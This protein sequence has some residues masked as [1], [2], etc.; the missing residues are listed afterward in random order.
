MMYT[1]EGGAIGGKVMANGG[2]SED[3]KLVFEKL[4]NL[5]DTS[6]KIWALYITWQNWFIGISAAA[7]GAFAVYFNQLNKV[8]GC[9][10]GVAICGAAVFGICAAR[11]ISDYEL[12]ARKKTLDLAEKVDLLAVST[13]ARDVSSQVASFLKISLFGIIAVWLVVI[14]ALVAREEPRHTSPASEQGKAPPV[15]PQGKPDAKQQ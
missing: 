7:L 3:K 10:T 15:S 2:D 12:I 11:K 9:A 13:A 4:K 5:Q 6:L 1:D 8:V 14:G